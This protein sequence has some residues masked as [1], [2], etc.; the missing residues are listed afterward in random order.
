MI[1]IINLNLLLYSAQVNPHLL[2]MN[3]LFTHNGF[4]IVASCDHTYHICCMAYYVSFHPCCKIVD[5]KEEF[6]HN[7]LVV[8]GIRP[9][10]EDVLTSLKIKSSMHFT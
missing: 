2:S 7:W 4:L 5:Y 8:V 10:S 6:Q 9:L 1:L 3:A